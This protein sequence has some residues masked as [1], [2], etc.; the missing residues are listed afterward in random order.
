MPKKDI[1]AMPKTW[2]EPIKAIIAQKATAKRLF[3]VLTKEVVVLGV[4]GGRT[5]SRTIRLPQRFR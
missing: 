3:E 4:A 2:K 5:T 1:S